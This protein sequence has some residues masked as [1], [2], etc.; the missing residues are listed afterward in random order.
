MRRPLLL[1]GQQDVLLVPSLVVTIFPPDK[2]ISPM[3]PSAF[4][5]YC[6]SRASSSPR[7]SRTEM[8]RL[9]GGGRSRFCWRQLSAPFLSRDL[10]SF[11]SQSNVTLAELLLLLS[12]LRLRLSC[13]TFGL[14][15]VFF[16]VERRVCLGLRR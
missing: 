13:S 5:P 6:F 14:D 7:Y 15:S 10:E 1:K 2:H 8:T 11:S 4:S 16:R 12:S 3:T 9:T